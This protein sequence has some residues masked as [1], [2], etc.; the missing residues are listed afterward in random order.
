MYFVLLAA[1]IAILV[2]VVVVAMGRG[3]EIM[4]FH[5]DQPLV[6]PRITTAADLATLRLPLGLFG[7][8]EHA[9]DA[10]LDAAARIFAE[11]DA[12]ICR[13]RAELWQMTAQHNGDAA[14]GSAD[15]GREQAR[16]AVSGQ[17][18]PQP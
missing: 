6:P 14:A 17:P 18:Q 5:R 2:G 3:G 12:E 1:A 7:Y 10:A 4:R 11:Q 9:A 16:D 13:L 8:Q 15:S